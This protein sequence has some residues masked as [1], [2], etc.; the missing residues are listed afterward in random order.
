VLP[1]FAEFPLYEL[2]VIEF[3]V[4]QIEGLSMGVIRPACLFIRAAFGTGSSIPGN[5][6]AADRTGFRSTH[7][8][9]VK[10]GMEQIASNSF[11]FKDRGVNG[12]RIEAP[13]AGQPHHLFRVEHEDFALA[14]SQ[15]F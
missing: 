6:R 1:F 5:I 12:G 14:K 3:I 7:S 10:L 8:G 4:R 2:V 13:I 15:G 9:S 11:V